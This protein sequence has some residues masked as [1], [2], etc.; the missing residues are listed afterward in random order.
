M[1]VSAS[2]SDLTIINVLAYKVIYPFY[3]YYNFELFYSKGPLGLFKLARFG[4][5]KKSTV[6]WNV[7]SLTNIRPW[8]N[9]SKQYNSSRCRM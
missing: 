5:D 4:N 6:K 8:T 9:F 1:F 2:E 7:M 3:A